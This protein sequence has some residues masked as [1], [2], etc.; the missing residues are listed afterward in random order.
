MKE[1]E[2]SIP[3]STVIAEAHRAGRMSRESEVFALIEERQ[4]AQGRHNI[5]AN[6]L[7]SDLVASD[8]RIAELES[9]LAEVRERDEVHRDSADI[10]LALTARIDRLEKELA[11]EREKAVKAIRVLT[12]IRRDIGEIAKNHVPCSPLAGRVEDAL[13][14]AIESLQTSA[15]AVPAVAETAYKPPEPCQCGKPATRMDPHNDGDCLL[16]YCDGCY[17]QELERLRKEW[18]V[19]LLAYDG[20]ATGLAKEAPPPA[21]APV[22]RL[23]RGELKRLRRGAQGCHD[24]QISMGHEGPVCTVSTTVAFKLLAAAERDIDQ[25][26]SDQVFAPPPD[27]D[28]SRAAKFYGTMPDKKSLPKTLPPGTSI[29]YQNAGGQVLTDDGLVAEKELRLSGDSYIGVFRHRANNRLSTMDSVP[30]R[31]VNWAKVPIA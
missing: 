10:T 30:A 18:G 19:E 17:E 9:Q 13:T 8:Q 24:A 2:K 21:S 26:E 12:E 1:D 20:K 25:H 11:A 16:E 5:E 4:Q 6:A 28:R 14:E 31:A 27:I 23:T 29:F 15:P 22:E 7:R 3:L